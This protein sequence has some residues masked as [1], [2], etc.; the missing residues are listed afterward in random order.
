[1]DVRFVWDE[2][3][4]KT[5][6]RKHRIS[7][8][9][10]LSCFYDPFHLLMND[11]EHSEHEERMV[12]IGISSNARLLVVVHAEKIENEIRIISARKAT[13]KERKQYEEV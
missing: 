5:N 6:K 12:L 3:K 2:R 13:K 10:A 11:P 7:F 4:N 1:M 8:E 9:E